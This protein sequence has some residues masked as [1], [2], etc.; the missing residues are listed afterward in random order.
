M[1]SHVDDDAMSTA[2][3]PFLVSTTHN[4]S[5]F[6]VEE[7]MSVLSDIGSDDGTERAS[8]RASLGA[9]L[10]QDDLMDDHVSDSASLAGGSNSG[11]PLK[12]SSVRQATLKNQQL[13]KQAEN[14]A[15][16][17]HLAK[18]KEQSRLAKHSS[19]LKRIEEDDLKLLKQ[20]EALNRDFR[21]HIN[22][23][24]VRPLGQD[25]FGNKVW[26]FDG[27]GSAPLVGQ[28]GIVVVGTGR[29][30]LQ[31]GTAADRTWWGEKAEFSDEEIQL[32]REKE[33]GEEGMLE[34]GEWAVLEDPEEV[35][36]SS[37]LDEKDDSYS[38]VP[39]HLERR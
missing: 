3:D 34:E 31:G 39:S 19:D 26:W 33:E 12:T 10:D 6:H 38:S 1:S 22:F 37:I 30:F 32:K 4:I 17:E 14:A 28:G 8:V 36:F 21:K 9:D 24:R 5:N 16:A 29:L 2:S 35:C 11:R 18:E 25:R 23:P 13:A 20:E 7:D 15:K 27:I